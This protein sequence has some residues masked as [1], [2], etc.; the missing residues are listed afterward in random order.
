[1]FK[2]SPSNN[3]FI[4]SICIFIGPACHV[5]SPLATA[6]LNIPS[7]WSDGHYNRNLNIGLKAITNVYYNFITGANHLC[8]NVLFTDAT[9]GAGT[10]Y[11]SWAPEFTDCFS[12]V[13]GAQP[14][15]FCVVFCKLLLNC[16]FVILWPLY[17]LSFELQPLITPLVSS[18]FLTDLHSLSHICT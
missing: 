9:G 1:M 10:A 3:S 7:S 14:F 12:G 18:H 13:A 17:Y 2:L 4:F 6:S 11:F 5:I 8:K 15:G 16:L